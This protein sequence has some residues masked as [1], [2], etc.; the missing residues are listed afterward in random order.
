MEDEATLAMKE[1]LERI[2]RLQEKTGTYIHYMGCGE[3]NFTQQVQGAD[4]TAKV[5]KK[6][7][8]MTSGD[9]KEAS[10]VTIG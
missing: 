3:Y 7:M 1:F 4:M 10:S 9:E 6:D 2:K 5:E 8:N